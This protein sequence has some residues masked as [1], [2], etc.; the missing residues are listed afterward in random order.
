MKPLALVLLTLF[1]STV[2][3]TAASAEEK[4]EPKNLLKP[5]NK[6]ESWRFEEHEGGKGELKID[7][8]AVVFHVTNI[9]GTDWHVQVYQTDLDLQEG[10]EYTLK[11]QMKSPEKRGAYVTAGIDQED[12]HNI[13]L[14]EEIFSAPVEFKD[15]SY[16]FT[17]TDVAKGKNRIGFVLGLEKGTAIVKNMTLT[18]GK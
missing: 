9:T 1:A 15:Y 3:W 14:Q 11:F 6:A 16:T 12:W 18:A 17:A 13:G 5:V 8:E 4:P 7:G 2:V 10:K